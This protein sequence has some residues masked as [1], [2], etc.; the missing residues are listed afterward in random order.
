MCKLFEI[1]SL[2]QAHII[3]SYNKNWLQGMIRKFF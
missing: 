2:I 3:L 1:G